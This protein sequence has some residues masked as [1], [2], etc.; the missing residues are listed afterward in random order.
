[1]LFVY[2]SV[3]L[4]LCKLDYCKSN[5]QISLKLGIMTGPTNGKNPLTF[6]GDTVPDMDSF[7]TAKYGILGDLLGFLLQSPAT[8]HKTR[9]S[10]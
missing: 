2:L 6:G 1:M 4:C 5:Q 9:L 7:S 10:N 8:F 3:C